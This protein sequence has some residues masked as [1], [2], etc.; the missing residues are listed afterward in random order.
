M[1]L[2]LLT[3]AAG[4]VILC[5]GIVLNTKTGLGVAPIN[6]VPFFVSEVTPLTLGTVTMI[7]YLVMIALECLLVRKVRL[8]FLLQLPV[9]VLFGQLVD[10]FNNWM[11]FRAEN[12]GFAFLYLF[13]AIVCTALGIDLVVG[14]NLV[15]NAPDA[16]VAV[17]SEVSGRSFGFT[18][19]IFDLTMAG[20]T[21]V[22]SLALEGQLIGIGVG[23]IVTALLCGRFAA[24]FRPPLA[25][26]LRLGEPAEKAAGEGTA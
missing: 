5:F 16:F 11:D 15:A 7:M 14:M 20:I 1:L 2:R 18:K 6:S 10:I 21:I 19:N 24:W 8:T 22:F 17:L 12:L 4:F 23:T 13:I 9:S 25:P 26:L 3:C